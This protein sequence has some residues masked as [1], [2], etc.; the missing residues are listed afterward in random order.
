MT[1][2]AKHIRTFYLVLVTVTGVMSACGDTQNKS[3]LEDGRKALSVGDLNAAQIHVKNV[4]RKAPDSSEARLLLGEVYLA[5]ALGQAAETELERAQKSGGEPDRVSTLLALAYAQQGKCEN[6]ETVTGPAL[7]EG[8]PTALDPRSKAL[9]LSA[10]GECDLVSSD[11]KAARINFETALRINDKCTHAMI[12]MARVTARA[13]PERAL[14]W[15]R[16]A[17][18]VSPTEAQA[19]TMLGDYHRVEGNLDAAKEAY[20]KSITVRPNN[21]YELL[22]RAL[23]NL[24]LDRQQEAE[25]DLS[26]ASAKLDKGNPYLEYVKGIAHLVRGANEDARNALSTAVAKIDGHGPAMFYL[27]EALYRSGKMEQAESYASKATLALPNLP[28]AKLLLAMIRTKTHEYEAAFETASSLR[29]EDQTSELSHELSAALKTKDESLIRT[30]LARTETTWGSLPKSFVALGVSP[31][32]AAAVPQTDDLAQPEA[33]DGASNRHA[34]AFKTLERGD[35]VAA[36]ELLNDLKS[37]NPA[38]PVTHNLLGIAHQRNGDVIKARAEFQEAL[39]LKPDYSQASNNLA[40]SFATDGNLDS[41]RNVLL[42]GLDKTPKHLG[43]MMGL[44][45]IDERRGDQRA[46]ELTLRKVIQFEPRAVA[47][48]LSLARMLVAQERREEAILLLE[49]GARATP[50]HPNIFQTL[51]TLY[52]EAKRPKDAISA[53][54]NLAK[55]QPSNAEVPFALAQANAALG[56]SDATEAALKQAV[57]LEPFR[58]APALAL[59]RLYLQEGKTTDASTLVQRIVTSDPGNAEAQFLRGRVLMAAGDSNSAVSAFEQAQELLPSLPVLIALSQAQLASG[60][61]DAARSVLQA[62]V[63]EHPNDPNAQYA[64]GEF[65]M[66]AGE[67]EAAIKA[68]K[69]LL[70]LAPRNPVSLNNLGWLL[71][72]R[73]PKEALEYA[74]AALQANPNEPAFQDTVA[75]IHAEQGRFEEAFALWEKARQSNSSNHTFALHYAD[76]LA[77]AKK[78]EQAQKVLDEILVQ[79]PSDDVAKA[80]REIQSRL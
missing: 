12:G 9:I 52:M 13:A 37:E 1:E 31:A 19:W 34:V 4:L 18:S 27:A 75:Q 70:K 68:F 38:D 25:A 21:A 74:A 47:S 36:L 65:L 56:K 32:P 61:R 45:E 17:V 76:A 33:Q 29:G 43:L 72:K 73:S 71:R 35:I 58:V 57:K 40:L 67:E 26:A 28:D 20:S 11:P 63:A 8:R 6:L 39:V 15:L 41:A 66:T 7:K 24:G 64:L 46:A 54:A 49:D 5:N 69:D 10:K 22:N 14:E 30:A 23:V 79:S 62:W 16:K 59:A 55:L 78:R 48:R 2:K 3:T 50:K 77:N 80:A 60:H 42:K 44:A 51:A 53:L